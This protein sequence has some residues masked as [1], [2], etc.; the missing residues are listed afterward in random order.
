MKIIST[1]SKHQFWFQLTAIFSMV[2]A[3]VGFSYNVWRMEVTE[4]NANIRQ[5]SFE[6]LLQLSELEHIVYANYYD[7]NDVLG[8]PRNGWVKVGLI[9]DLSLITSNDL[10]QAAESLKQVWQLH[11]EDYATN[12]DSVDK[13]VTSIDQTRAAVRNRLSHL[14]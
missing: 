14:K 7:N 6:M 4:H 1:I 2:F 10:N 13:I 5:S 8:N 3:L 12:P 11:W 9:H